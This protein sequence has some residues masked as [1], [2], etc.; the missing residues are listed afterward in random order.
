MLLV[1]RFGA[2]RVIETG[3]LS[4]GSPFQRELYGTA[5]ALI[6]HDEKIILKS[7]AL[8]QFDGTEPDDLPEPLP[9][10]FD[11]WIHAIQN[12]ISPMDQKS[13]VLRLHQVNEV[14]ALSDRAKLRM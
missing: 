11:Q 4:Y 14:G 7:K 12:H 10:P 2:L 1:Y 5:G 13:D 6:I 3:F 9:L 8:G